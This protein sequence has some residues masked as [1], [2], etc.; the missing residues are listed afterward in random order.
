REQFLGASSQA[1]VKA[2]SAPGCRDFIVAADPIDPDRVN[3]YEEW[4]TDSQLETFRSGGPTQ[5]LTEH[6]VAADVFRYRIASSGP[7]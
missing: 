5:A 3:V 6:I 2:R 7:A 4:E 1:M